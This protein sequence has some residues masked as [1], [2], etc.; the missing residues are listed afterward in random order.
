[1]RPGTSWFGKNEAKDLNDKE[2]QQVRFE[3]YLRIVRDGRDLAQVP[4]ANVEEQVVTPSLTAEEIYTRASRLSP[5]Q[6]LTA[7]ARRK[8][9]KIRSIELKNDA[10]AKWIATFKVE[11]KTKK[12]LS[13]KKAKGK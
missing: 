1:M 4:F 11:R 2:S 3:S 13:L 9:E 12:K 6:E 7:R 8:A 10:E 5:D